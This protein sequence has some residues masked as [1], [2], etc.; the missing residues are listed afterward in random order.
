MDE[1]NTCDNGG[2]LESLRKELDESNAALQILTS[3]VNS[4][5]AIM[6]VWG[7]S[8]DQPLKF[9][10]DGIRRFGYAPDEL[11]SGEV[12]YRDLI[13]PE[14]RARRDAEVRPSPEPGA[15]K[16]TQEYRIAARSGEIRWVEDRNIVF[17]DS[18]GRVTH[19][20]STIV[21]ITERK[22]META[23]RDS[24]ANLNA[25]QQ[26]AHVG[27]WRWDLRA[28]T[29]TLSDETL[30]IHGLP[31]GAPPADAQ[32]L[33]Q[34][35][36]HPEDR[37]RLNGIM[38]DI[39]AGGE[40]RDVTF[41]I[42]RTD[43]EVRWLATT[44]HRVLEHG[45]DGRPTVLMGTVQDVTE[46]QIAQV[47]LQQSEEKYRA[48][49]ESAGEAICTLSVDGV[50][51]FMNT[52][53]A[54]RLG[55]V[56]GELAG[57]T[58]WDVFPKEFAD[59][60]VSR[61]RDAITAAKS[62]TI[63]VIVPLDE[64]MR[65][66]QISMEPVR[67]HDGQVR[68]SLVIARDIHEYKTAVIALQ[69]SESH[70][71]AI[72]HSLHQTAILVYGLDGEIISC[73]ASPEMDERYGIDTESLAGKTL[74]EAFGPEVADGRMRRIKD[75][76]RNGWP[77]RDEWL[78][79]LPKGGF[80]VETTMSPLRDSG[81]HIVN[82][83]AFA[84][85]I[86]D[87]KQAEEQL[88]RS[89]QRY[90]ALF[91]GGGEGILVADVETKKYMFANP[92][93]C[94]MLDYSVEEFLEMTIA[95]CHRPEDLPHVLNRFEAQA[96]GDIKVAP[97]IP[98]LTRDGEVVYAD[99]SAALIEFEGRD[100]AVGFIRDL[101]DARR[102]EEALKIAHVKLMNARD[103]ERKYIA[104]ELHDSISQKL[105]ALG[106]RLD[107]VGLDG[108]DSPAETCNELAG[109]IR[110]IC[111]GLYP[112]AL[113]AL[114]LISALKQLEGHY[115]ADELTTA[116]RC[117]GKIARARFEP[118]VEIA[119]FRIAQEAVNNAF[120]YSG[121]SNIDIDLM[122]ADRRLVLTIFDD[123]RGFN[124][125]D[126]EGSGL[127]LAT[128]QDRARAIEAEMTIASEP[129]ETRIEVSVETDIRETDDQKKG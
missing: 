83:V 128:M 116:I 115:Q 104:S 86:T 94:K 14:D 2:E 80:W 22:R 31:P 129:G 30:R 62:S 10:S 46:Q 73:W 71:R 93:I 25:A 84:R 99:V 66:Y 5:P 78:T 12:S 41:R 111:H 26:L 100:C 124:V 21:D 63:E 121:G 98:F 106:M 122:Y 101:T 82:V 28:E 114:G 75:V 103:E 36:V 96:R 45:E 53:C 61:A 69:K 113:E 95:D 126:A 3:I 118:E 72:M 8:E 49:V 81:G 110:R 97:N 33:L 85:D 17:R 29:F 51:L 123:G 91:E 1:N 59:L 92:A 77:V 34:S 89:E 50:F 56:A 7:V 67:D 9:I 15:D 40:G 35:L 79:V 24:E 27:S 47:A 120:R 127:G 54:Q 87:R 39:L 112:P 4:S 70:L 88:V 119:L 90:R 13:L 44:G 55:G 74:K 42:T 105:V 37:E 109:D 23:L 19:V 57:K 11:L 58:L 48:V 43:G 60:E 16:Y 18:E 76:V 117:D 38:E 20:Q 52:V 125:K 68:S 102:A 65:W 107:S 32:V 64:E 108:V 6:C